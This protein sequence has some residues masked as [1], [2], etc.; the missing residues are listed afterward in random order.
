MSHFPRLLLLSLLVAGAL[1]ILGFSAGPAPAPPSTSVLLS[2]RP[3]DG[4]I[5]ST[6]NLYFTSHDGAGAA[7]WRMAQTELPDQERVLYW[8]AGGRFGDIVFAQINGNFFGYFFA[9]SAGNITIKRIPLAGGNATILGS[10]GSDIDIVNSHHNL[11]TDGVNLY[12]QDVNSIRKMPIAGG[13]STV[14]DNC[15][16]NTPTAG[17]ALQG[18][19]IIYASVA[20]IRFVPT[21]GAITSPTVRTI[22]IASS[23][24]T[25]LYAD[26][27]SVY[28]GEQNGAIRRKAG[29]VTTTLSP[30]PGLVP[31]SISVNASA[32]NARAWTQCG[33][34][35]CQL[36]LDSGVNHST[37]TIGAN[38]FG[39]AVTSSGNAF[40]G[41]A[42]GVH[43]A[44]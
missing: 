12:W 17:I 3:P 24:V 41:D 10:V 34:Q 16:P 9:Q 13:T 39:V 28:W 31:T 7:V 22:A 1:A 37:P 19:S 43:R 44:F 18:T 36:S 25:A 27:T 42:A 5:L 26:S 8:E 33:S 23:R 15:N 32:G 4:L 14:L 40:W 38:A 20:D 29:S 21:S 6:G 30:A 35:S 11:V 2:S